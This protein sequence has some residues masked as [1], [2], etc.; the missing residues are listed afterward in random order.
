MG[1]LKRL[2]AP[3]HLKIHVKEKVFTVCPRPGPH[4]KFECIPLLLIVRDYLGYAE[5][6][7]EAKKIIKSGK[8]FVDGRPVKDPKFP[9]GLMDVISIPETGENYR[10]IPIYRRGL[11]LIEIP[12]E[13][14]R[15]KLCRIIRKMHVSGGH[16]QITLHDGRN[17][18][19]KELTEEVMSYRTKDTLKISIPSQ[20]ILEHLK[21]QENMYGLLIKG[22]K[23]GLHG[24]IV[25]LKTDVV[26]PAR[27]LV[28]L[29]TDR[30][31]VTSLLDYLM[32]VGSDKPLVRLP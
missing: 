14:A 25:E 5:R 31:E 2:A 8:I 10:I 16:L 9:A 32:V 15:Y 3:P 4:P 12:E 29:S 19:F 21:L 18:R 28:K 6:A 22:P 27:P 20:M 30:G 26:Y 7:E 13:E 23:Q 11:D 1:H 24:K 17:I